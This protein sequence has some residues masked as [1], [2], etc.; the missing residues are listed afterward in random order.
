MQNRF[1]RGSVNNVMNSID[2]QYLQT[3][4]MNSATNERRLIADGLQRRG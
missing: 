4:A 2:E 1:N 3:V